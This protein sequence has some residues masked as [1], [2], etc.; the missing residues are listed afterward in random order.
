MDKKTIITGSIGILLVGFLFANNLE[1]QGK[2][3]KNSIY[4]NPEHRVS[5][6]YPKDWYLED[7]SMPEPMSTDIIS[8]GPESIQFTED[9]PDIGPIYP[10]YAQMVPSAKPADLERIIKDE[11]L[12]PEQ[13]FGLKLE[14][15]KREDVTVAGIFAV[16]VS[17]LGTGVQ[18]NR[19]IRETFIPLAD[20]LVSVFYISS[21]S[22]PASDIDI[23][24]HILDS[25]K[26]ENGR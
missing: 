26:F 21:R 6:E 23:Y 3:N 10:I 2:A 15:V 22:E 19:Y 5:F 20:K 8:L 25:I 12:S 17:G 4:F 18:N 11:L 7:L 24:N 13:G 1:T 9:M 16:K 14:T